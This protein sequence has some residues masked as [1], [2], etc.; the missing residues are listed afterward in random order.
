MNNRFLK[1]IL[2]HIIY[3]YNK[4]M[5]KTQNYNKEINVE[6]NKKKAQSIRNLL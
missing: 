5:T 3:I 4:E 6:N 2:N 1:K